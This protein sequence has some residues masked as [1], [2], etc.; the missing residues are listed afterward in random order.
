MRRCPLKSLEHASLQESIERYMAKRYPHLT[1]G[2][3]A[4]WPL[5]ARV[6]VGR[7][8]DYW[9]IIVRLHVRQPTTEQ[10]YDV[11]YDHLTRAIDRKVR[12]LGW[13]KP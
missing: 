9:P 8:H 5:G 12:G 3:V 7:G 1:F 10:L 4:M 6:I 2:P 11:L 13:T